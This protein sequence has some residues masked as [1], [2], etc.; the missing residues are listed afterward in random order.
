VT[1]VY[2]TALRPTLSPD[3]GEG[4]PGL[5]VGEVGAGIG[6][7]D[8]LVVFVD[9]EGFGQHEGHL[10][11]DEKA[12]QARHGERVGVE[13]EG[14]REVA[15]LVDGE[16]GPVADDEGIHVVLEGDAAL[17]FFG[18]LGQVLELL[19]LGAAVGFA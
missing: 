19:E 16:E 1:R 5:L 3:G 10:V 9:G 18:A 2:G 14:Q 4:Y 7:E 15:D 11:L 17:E 6:L 12:G 8:D 13:V